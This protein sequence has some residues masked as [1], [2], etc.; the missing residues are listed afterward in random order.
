VRHRI[1]NGPHPEVEVALPDGSVLTAVRGEKVEVPDELATR[2]DEQGETWLEHEPKASR[3]RS[4]PKAS[5][6][7]EPNQTTGNGEE[8]QTS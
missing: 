1:Y 6:E 7:D 3:A 2:L 8:D 4:K 5:K